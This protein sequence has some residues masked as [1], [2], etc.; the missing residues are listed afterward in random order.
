M[1]GKLMTDLHWLPDL[2]QLND[3]N[4]NW[5]KYLSAVYSFFYQDFV[6]SRPIFKGQILS[7]KRYPL[8]ENKEI[9]FWH[10]ISEGNEETERT[11]D[12]RRCERI[13]WPRPIIENFQNPNIKIWENSRNNEVRICIFLDN[14]DYLVVLAK[15]RGYI[16]LWT[17]YPITRSHQKRK[18]MK[19]YHAYINANAA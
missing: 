16:L 4:G 12:F 7:L 2:V 10:I 14:V 1:D 13:R 6:V 9:T 3:F 5:E 11:P 15:R 17:A 19:E 18:L 8:Y